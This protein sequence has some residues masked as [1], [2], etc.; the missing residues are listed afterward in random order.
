MQFYRHLSQLEKMGPQLRAVTVGA[1]DGIHLGHQEILRQLIGRAQEMGGHALVMSF[2][3]LPR[4]FFSPDQP[5]ARLTRF[6]ERYKLLADFGIE[7]FFC[8]KFSSIRDLSPQHFIQDIL[9]KGLNASHI[10]VGEDFRFAAQR[11]G[12]LDCLMSAGV[13]SGFGVTAVPGVCYKNQRASSTLIRESLSIGDMKT[14]CGMLGRHYSISGKVVRGLG[15]GKKLGFPTANVNLNRR[16]T[17]VDGIFAA[18]ISGLADKE[19]DG[20]ASVGTRPTVGGV[21][22]LLEVF[23]FNFDE[24][25]YGKYI[26]VHFVERLREERKYLDVETMKEQMHKDVAEAQLI[27]SV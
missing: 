22:P 9:V 19:L 5:A 11:I 23:I 3:P 26:T 7:E 17:P 2:E 4:E 16:R 14:V 13:T 27:L 25:I 21:E 18:R 15:L 24:E 12:T 1:Y 20:V 10:V 6:R 8:P